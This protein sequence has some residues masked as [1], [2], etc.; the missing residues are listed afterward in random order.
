MLSTVFT[1]EIVKYFVISIILILAFRIL[2]AV[3]IF[4]DAKSKR[5]KNSVLYFLFAFVFPIITGIIYVSKRNDVSKV[6]S[7]IICFVLSIISLISSI[8]YTFSFVLPKINEATSGIIETIVEDK[9]DMKGNLIDKSKSIEEIPLYDKNGNVYLYT[10][11]MLDS[12]TYSD[13]AAYVNQSD[14][15]VYVP[16]NCF[17]DSEGYFYYDENNA[18]LINDEDNY[19][20]DDGNLYYSVSGIYWDKDGK[21]KNYYTEMYN[22]S[23]VNKLFDY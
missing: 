23:G 2:F 1:E 19:E 14:K 22:N 17:V 5:T 9:Y 10:E 11:N 13:T 6:V 21:I 18:L 16:S 7:S 4:L 20:D 15:S 8:G 3:S 12:N